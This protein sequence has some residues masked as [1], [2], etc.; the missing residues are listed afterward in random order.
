[1]YRAGPTGWATAR[2]RA[3]SR[4]PFGFSDVVGVT[5]G[6]LVFI[7]GQMARDAEG[8]LVGA[9]VDIAAIAHLPE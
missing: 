7:T 1:M 6:R 2:A 9:L 4:S 5:G 3:H 8:K